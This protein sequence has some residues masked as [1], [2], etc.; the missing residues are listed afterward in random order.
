MKD[1]IDT[2]LGKCTGFLSLSRY[3][4]AMRNPGLGNFMACKSVL[5]E[6]IDGSERDEGSQASQGPLAD[7]GP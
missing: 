1:R 2:V 7:E 5:M 4:P 6:K 3:V